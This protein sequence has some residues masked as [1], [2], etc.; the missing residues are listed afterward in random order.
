[1]TSWQ[2]NH[3]FPVFFCNFILFVVI[4]ATSPPHLLRPQPLQSQHHLEP[5][6]WPPAIH[7]N[8]K[9]GHCK[10]LP[11]RHRLSSS[12]QLYHQSLASP[13]TTLSLVDSRTNRPLLQCQVNP[14]S[15]LLLLLI[16]PASIIPA[17]RTK[18]HSAYRRQIN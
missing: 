18:I 15:L 16:F 8:I 3:L 6:T 4:S 2:K 10:L 12:N 14:F 13:P 7:L 11:L 17:C 5:P 9:S 1:M